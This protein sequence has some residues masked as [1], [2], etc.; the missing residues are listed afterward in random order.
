MSFLTEDV[1]PF[2]KRQ[3]LLLFVFEYFPSISFQTEYVLPFSKQQVLSL[4]VF[5]YTSN[6]S[7]FQLMES[8]NDETERTIQGLFTNRSTPK[9]YRGVTGVTM[10]MGE[11]V[12]GWGVSG[13]RNNDNIGNG[14]PYRNVR[15]MINDL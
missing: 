6:L 2:S 15:C 8:W 9:R 4:F 12:W 1:L 5:E 10:V 7:G 14:R 13:G 11:L 3:S